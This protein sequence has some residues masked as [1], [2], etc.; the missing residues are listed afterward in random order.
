MYEIWVDEFDGRGMHYLTEYEAPQEIKAALEVFR[1]LDTEDGIK[2]E[3][4]IY[5]VERYAT[6]VTED[7]EDYED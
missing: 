4:C 2:A 6:D 5:Y 3:Y 1:R 7:F